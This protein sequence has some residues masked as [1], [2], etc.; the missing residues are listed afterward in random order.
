M[1]NITKLYQLSQEINERSGSVSSAT[2][3]AM[4]RSYIMEII[5]PLSE[6]IQQSIIKRMEEL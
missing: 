4:I 6:E 1:T 5:S 2:I 3:E